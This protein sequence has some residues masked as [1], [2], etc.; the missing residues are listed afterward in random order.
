MADMIFNNIDFD[1]F[2]KVENI[3]RSMMPPRDIKSKNRYNHIGGRFAR[4]DMEAT[5]IEVDIRIYTSSILETR[6]RVR[7]VAALLHT[8]EPK[9]LILR[10][11]PTLY[12]WGIVQGD[13]AMERLLE[14]ES[15][16]LIFHC[17]DPLSYPIMQQSVTVGETFSITNGGAYEIPGVFTLTTNKVTN[18]IKLLQISTGDFIYINHNFIIGDTL[19]IDLEEESVYKNNIDIMKD[20]YFESDFFHIPRGV[21]NYTLNNGTGVFKYREGWF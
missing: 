11:Q 18:F 15:T 16:T 20:V 3:R 8:D 7:Q 17:D 5:T 14:T 13:T 4:V 19:V 10:D 2:L 1:S 21:S 6:E 9:K 12:N